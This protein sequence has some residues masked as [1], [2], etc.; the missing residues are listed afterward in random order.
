VVSDLFG[1]TGR[2]LIMLLMTG[3]KEIRIEDIELCA[4]G[5]LQGKISELHRSIQGFYEEHHCFQLTSLM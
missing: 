1:V 3:P 2:N 4:K 5:R